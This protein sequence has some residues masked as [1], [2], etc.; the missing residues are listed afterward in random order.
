MKQR[1][2][3]PFKILIDGGCPLCRREAA[4]LRR[5][6]RGAGRLLIEDISCPEFDAGKYRRTM[7]ELMAEIHGVQPDG[8]VVRGMDVFRQ[9]YAAVGWSWLAAPTGW[10]VLRP[11]TDRVYRWFARNRLRLACRLG[12]TC[13]RPA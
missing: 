1:Q 5:L 3:Q 6:D 12:G 7:D 4:L 9:A 13:R 2:L 10:P 8:Q 11:L